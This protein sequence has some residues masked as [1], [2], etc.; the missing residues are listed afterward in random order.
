ME[1]AMQPSGPD[2]I[3]YDQSIKSWSGTLPEFDGLNCQRGFPG[4]SFPKTISNSFKTTLTLVPDS[5]IVA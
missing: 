5:I 4:Q 1:L 2:Q 3:L